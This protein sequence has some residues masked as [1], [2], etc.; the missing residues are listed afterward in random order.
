MERAVHFQVPRSRRPG[1]LGKGVFDVIKAPVPGQAQEG[2]GPQQ[3]D[4]E[5][6]GRPPVPGRGGRK[7][8]G[9]VM[10]VC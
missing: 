3:A 8:S 4:L 2:R 6:R 10:G 7:G 9:W 1:G 5:L